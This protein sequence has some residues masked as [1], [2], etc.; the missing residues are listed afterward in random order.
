ML[1]TF[2]LQ[3]N[4][5]SLVQERFQ[6]FGKQKIQEVKVHPDSFIQMALQLAYFSLHSRYCSLKLLNI[7][8]TV[9]QYNTILHINSPRHRSKKCFKN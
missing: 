2:M 7:L 5:Y 4:K 1:I 8:S 6:Q 3:K 9:I